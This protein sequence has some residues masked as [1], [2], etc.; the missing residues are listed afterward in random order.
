[1]REGVRRSPEQLHARFGHLLPGVV[2]HL[3]E[4]SARLG[5]RRSRRCDVDVV[6]REVRRAELGEELEGR[7]HLHPGGLHRVR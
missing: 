7:I 2:D 1:M 5:E 3:V 4:V 6:E